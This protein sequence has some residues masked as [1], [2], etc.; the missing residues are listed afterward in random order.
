MGRKKD[1]I[2]GGFVAIE[3][4]LLASEQWGRLSSKAVHVYILVRQKFNGKNEDDL[5]LT[6]REVQNKMSTA[7]FSKALKELLNSEIL[8]MVRPG[9]I[10]R[11]C[12]IFSIRNKWFFKKPVCKGFQS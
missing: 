3:K 7:T 4:S 5:S 6:Y 9:G 10:E 12:N 2:I 1:K 11:K 8:I